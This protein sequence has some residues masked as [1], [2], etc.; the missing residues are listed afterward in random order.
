MSKA[1]RKH[2]RYNKHSRPFN[3]AEMKQFENA[4]MILTKEFMREIEIEKIL[5]VFNGQGFDIE[6]TTDRKEKYA[7]TVQEI[8]E[9][10][11]Y[12]MLENNLLRL[13]LKLDSDSDVLQKTELKA[14]QP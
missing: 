12:Y 10:L 13:S 9:G 14:K 7:G 3:V 5:V 11:V 2:K 4:L 6:Y 8:T 1:K